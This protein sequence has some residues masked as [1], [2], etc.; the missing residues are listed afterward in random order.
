MSILIDFLKMSIAP[1]GT[2]GFIVVMLGL[3]YFIGRRQQ[4]KRRSRRRAIS[5][6]R[7]LA[8]HEEQSRNRLI[9]QIYELENQNAEIENEYAAARTK[10]AITI[11]GYGAAKLSEVLTACAGKECGK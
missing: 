3:V 1:L 2:M 11:K 7:E 6:Q 5:R 10:Q 9:R 4:A 8:R